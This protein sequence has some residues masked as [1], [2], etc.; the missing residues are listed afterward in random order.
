MLHLVV[1]RR[2][3]HQAAVCDVPRA[4]GHGRQAVLDRQGGNSR[5]LVGEH[6]VGQHE[7]RLSARGLYAVDCSIEF[8]RLADVLDAHR[9]AEPVGRMLGVPFEI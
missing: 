1:S 6:H 8:V 9:N 7:K 4:P 2:M 3:G 5:R